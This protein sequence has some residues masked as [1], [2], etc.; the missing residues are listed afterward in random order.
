M[1]T[2][3]KQI[4]IVGV[5]V[6]GAFVMVMLG[7]WQ[8]QVFVDQGN[9]GV[10]D[11]AAQPPVALDGEVAADGTVGD[12]YGK[13]VTIVGRYLDGQQELIPTGVGWRVLAAF[14]VRDGRVLPVVRGL[15]TAPGAVSAPPTGEQT[16]VGLFLPGEGDPEPGSAG[17]SVG[18]DEL[19]SV[20]MP[21]L[22]QRWP[23]Q[24]IPGFVTLSETDAAA[25]GLEPAPVDLPAG[26]GASRNSG[27]ALQWWVFAAFGLGMAIKLTHGLGVRERRTQDTAVL[28][29]AHPDHHEADSR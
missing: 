22:A 14:E 2:R 15:T 16:E 11:R 28:A 27:Y 29:S 17:A 12:I 26:E 21:L 24:L 4:L 23:Q 7:L 8:M 5:G 18:A 9:R 13:Q 20:R 6:I 25:H 3:L 10:A 19:G 1:S